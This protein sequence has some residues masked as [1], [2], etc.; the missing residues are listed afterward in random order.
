[1]HKAPS[2][3]EENGGNVCLC[4]AMLA[5]WMVTWRHSQFK[6]AKGVPSITAPRPTCG[7]PLSPLA[8]LS[9]C[10][11]FSKTNAVYWFISHV[12][13]SDGCI[14]RTFRNYIKVVRRRTSL[15]PSQQLQHL[16]VSYLLILVPKNI[17][18]PTVL[19]HPQP[20]PHSI[21]FVQSRT[22]D[23]VQANS[24]ITFH[25]DSYPC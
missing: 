19:T 17:H 7:T 10:E 11:V 8:D 3:N 5:S 18:I 15:H 25:I 13:H 1:M 9:A 4:W 20:Y 14:H 22:L 2:N 21:P 16:L 24:V 23:D 6:S 12:Q